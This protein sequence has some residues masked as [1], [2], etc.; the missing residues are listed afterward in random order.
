MRQLVRVRDHYPHHESLRGMVGVLKRVYTDGTV[1]VLFEEEPHK[2]DKVCM[3][4][5]YVELLS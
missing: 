2:G 1:L 3:D 5:R 4:R